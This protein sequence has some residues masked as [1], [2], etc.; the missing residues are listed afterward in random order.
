[1]SRTV[2]F[3][4]IKP[5]AVREKHIGGIVQMIEQAGFEVKAL[6]LTQLTLEAAKEFYAVHAERPF[7]ESMCKSMTQG[8]IVV[9]KLEKD[10]AVA[11][12]RQL[13]GATNPAEAA[14]GTIRK[15]FGKS[16]ESNAIHGSDADE[17][18]AAEVAFFFSA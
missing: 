15:R 18:A 5:D 8:P 12:F 3:S 13:I 10:N 9:M 6:R 14:E 7:Y 17:T 4:M 1:M 11:D 2:T 16:I